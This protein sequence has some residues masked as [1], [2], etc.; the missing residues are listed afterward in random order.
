MYNNAIVASEI[1]SILICIII[2]YGTVFET[3]IADGRKWNLALIIGLQILFILTD[4]LSFL[5]NYM[6]PNSVLIIL[7]SISF[8]GGFF[9]LALFLNY[10]Y[11]VESEKGIQIGTWIRPMVAFSTASG[12]LT[13]VLLFFG[14]LF[15]YRDEVYSVKWGYYIY[16]L[17]YIMLFIAVIIFLVRFAKVI[18]KH[19]SWAFFSY[20]LTPIICALITSINPDFGFGYVASTI[21]LLLVYIMLQSNLHELNEQQNQVYFQSIA[22]VYNSMHLIDFEE[23]N[24]S[25]FSATSEIHNYL[26]THKN[27]NLQEMMWGVMS[28]RICEAHRDSIMKFTDFSTLAQRMVH[29]NS[30]DIELIGVD[31][32]WFRFSFIR[33]GEEGN[34][35]PKVFFASQDI[36]ESKR[37]ENNLI[38]MSNTDELT[39]I[40]I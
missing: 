37:K 18:S 3:K 27:L 10:L 17:L 38:L 9:V 39:Q 7:A 5:P 13:I 8:V 19:D 30:I 24:F 6:V 11:L 31:N 33:I 14:A 2:L 12:V 25:E 35:L 16:M 22:S 29:R 21:S 26:H 4:V 36:D 1:V 15:S 28:Q 40:Y 32:K 34:G 20:F 23:N